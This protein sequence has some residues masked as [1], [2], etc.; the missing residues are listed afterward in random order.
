MGLILWKRVALNP[1][2]ERQYQRRCLRISRNF[3]RIDFSASRRLDGAHLTSACVL[4]T[5]RFSSTS[6]SGEP[7]R[8]YALSMKEGKKLRKLT[9]DEELA[10]AAA[11][12]TVA[13]RAAAIARVYP[14]QQ[15]EFAAVLLPRPWLDGEK[16][17][18]IAQIERS[19]HGGG[20]DTDHLNEPR[21]GATAVARPN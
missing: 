15:V 9:R 21:T 20:A 13:E 4:A 14:L 11:P 17:Q 19:R 18:V 1:P 10:L 12:G 16:E 8:K 5:S 7:L 2:S 6:Q 3:T